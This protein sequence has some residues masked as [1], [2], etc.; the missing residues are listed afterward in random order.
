MSRKW[1]ELCRARPTSATEICMS[2][3]TESPLDRV[4]KRALSCNFFKAQPSSVKA[5]TVTAAVDVCN[6]QQT[7]GGGSLLMAVKVGINGFGRIGRNIY[8][9]AI[10]D[11]DIDF[12]AVNDITD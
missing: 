1:D 7:F 12:V 6:R 11:P 5:F 8:R 2:L 3:A 4:G 9:T 10:G